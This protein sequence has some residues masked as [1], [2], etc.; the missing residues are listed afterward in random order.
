MREGGVGVGGGGCTCIAVVSGIRVD[1]G[2][3]GTCGGRRSGGMVSG[4]VGERHCSRLSEVFDELWKKTSTQFQVPF[5]FPVFFRVP[6]RTKKVIVK[7][8]W[9]AD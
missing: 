2:V 9:L 1:T 5:F 3:C 4:G 6:P 7:V 8:E